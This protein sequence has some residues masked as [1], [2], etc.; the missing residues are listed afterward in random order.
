MFNLMRFRDGATGST[1]FRRLARPGRHGRTAMATLGQSGQH[2]RKIPNRAPIARFVET[3]LGAPL[4][5]LE[6]VLQ[7]L[8]VKPTRWAMR[9]MDRLSYR[10]EG[11]FLRRVLSH[12]VFP[13]TLILSLFLGFKLVEN[14][15]TSFTLLGFVL[16]PIVFG[17]YCAPLERL[18]PF[19]RNWLEG[20]NDTAVDVI[21]YFSGAFWSGIS[22]LIVSAL[23]IVGVVEVLEPYG[24]DLWRVFRD[25]CEASKRYNFRNFSKDIA[26]VI[27]N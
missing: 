19:S 24:H 14:G 1:A 7:W 4:N 22:K 8:L 9:H 20:G 21:M 18:M 23:F 17:L 27:T 26:K 15:I 3:W 2:N 13:F 25:T 16:L 6:L 11:T 5:L 10:L 12:T